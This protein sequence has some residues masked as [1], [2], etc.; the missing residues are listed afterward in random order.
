MS[1]PTIQ[2]YLVA[3]GGDP[4]VADPTITELLDAAASSGGGAGGSLQVDNGVDDPFEAA[5]LVIPGATESA[6]GVASL[7]AGTGPWLE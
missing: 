5:M 7:P 2:D 3:L 4:A 1:D 6:P